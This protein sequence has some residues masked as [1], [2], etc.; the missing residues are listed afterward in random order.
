MT[1]TIWYADKDPS[2][3]TFVEFP[4]LM[5]ASQL[6]GVEGVELVEYPQTDMWA[7]FGRMGGSDVF[8][9][10]ANQYIKRATRAGLLRDDADRTGGQQDF[11]R[12]L[13]SK[14]E[15]AKRAAA[16]TLAIQSIYAGIHR[17][18]RYDALATE[19][20]GPESYAVAALGLAKA[21]GHTW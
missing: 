16:G 3:L 8:F 13:T 14:N 6:L 20:T 19:N 11:I 21:H 1:S 4:A 7:M 12:G 15:I 18:G 5:D 2:T 17:I 10:I 9:L